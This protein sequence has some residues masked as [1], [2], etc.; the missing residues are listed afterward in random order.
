MNDCSKRG[1]GPNRSALY[2][3][4]VKLEFGVNVSQGCCVFASQM[5]LLGN[6][7]NNCPLNVPVVIACLHCFLETRM[8]VRSLLNS[9]FVSWVWLHLYTVMGVIGGANIWVVTQV[10]L[11]DLF[12]HEFIEVVLWFSVWYGL[13][14]E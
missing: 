4:T 1:V 14:G 11:V 8:C 10:L 7:V 13:H 3:Y 6:C 5:E 12:R 9:P 2:L